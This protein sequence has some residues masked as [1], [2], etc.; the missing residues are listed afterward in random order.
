MSYFNIYSV[1]VEAKGVAY[2]TKRA[3]RTH[4]MLTSER[5]MQS[6]GCKTIQTGQLFSDQ[7]TMTGRYLSSAAR[8]KSPNTV[9]KDDS[10]TKVG[11]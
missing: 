2:N 10:Y 4:R 7:R 1:C 8:T 6:V 3:L 5:I 11:N 9:V